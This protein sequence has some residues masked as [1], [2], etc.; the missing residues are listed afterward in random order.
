MSGEVVRPDQR[1]RET[2]FYIPAKDAPERP[3]YTLKHNDTFAV[4][5]SHGDIGVASGESDGMFNQDTRFL[6]RLEL[7]V[8]NKP[9]LLLGSGVRSDNEM[10][11]A[12]LTNPDFI[13]DHGNI[14]LSKDS[15]H[16]VRTLFVWND[17]LFTR[18]G[19]HNFAD[20]DVELQMDL[21]FGN[22]FADIFEA[23]GM[24][25]AKRG[26]EATAVLD[27]NDV[28]LQYTSL[29]GVPYTTTVHFDPAPNLLSEHRATYR[30]RLPPKGR[31]SVFIAIAVGKIHNKRGSDFFLN[32]RSSA[33]ARV[34]TCQSDI[35]VHTSSD[36]FNQIV[37][38]SLADLRL[39]MTHTPE[40]NYP[41]AG[42]PWYSTTFGRDG[43][44][45]A[46]QLL[47]C[48]PSV[49]SGVLRKL[50]ALQATA[51]DPANDAEPGKIIHEMRKGEMARLR[52]VP[53]GRYYGS[54]D[55]TPLFVLLAGEYA[56][57]TGDFDLIS[58]LWPNIE[59]AL[60]WID[61]H[62]LK[63]P[64]GFLRHARNS[65][66]G[67]V[68]QG[69]K[70][71]YDSIFHA[72]GSLA[73]G[74]IALVEVQ[75][76]VVAAKRSIAPVARQLGFKEKADRLL[77]DADELASRI[78]QFFWSE[79]LNI[80]GI[81]LDGKGRLCRV[82][83]SNAGHVLYSGAASHDRAR[84]VMQTML[85]PT[86]LSGWGL[87]TVADGE[88]RYNP[89]SYHNGSIWPH[90]NAL[91][92]LGFARYGF[93][94]AAATVLEALSGAAS[95][96]ELNRLPELFC[97]FRRSKGQAP[98]NYPVACS[99]QA[100]ASATPLALLQACLGFAFDVRQHR[101]SVLNP[102]LPSFID[103]AVVRNLQIGA[104]LVDVGFYRDN[105]GAVQSEVLRNEAN[106]EVV[107][108]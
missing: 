78:E 26:V 61:S 66:D 1:T 4:I 74:T 9:T 92:A 105:R 21:L 38:R 99:P 31:S 77:R 33:R 90:D 94:G 100:W 44:I 107:T 81:A 64:D 82:K 14:L 10:V 19:I 68:N 40:G 39:L 47:W 95:R 88:S 11:R 12:D 98:T 42:V 96:M 27:P 49:A 85:S 50:A 62:S 58:K 101:I 108:S 41:Y 59:A 3:R 24:R 48:M 52:E 5:D 22:D 56:E 53:F 71:S 15:I 16:I 86:F 72:D 83:T 103:K 79:E 30:L 45:T 7:L 25:R 43:L 69:W 13:D 106:V 20:R 97:G 104:H 75:A 54:V 18:L 29:D 57:R 70:D 51:F 76:Y 60:E 87:R 102:V 93:K 65:E 46:L 89:M 2:P 36:I 80:Y 6:S 23:R 73:E 84:R 63:D 55:A 32:L 91:A 8:N 34:R 37:A 67:L 17:T 28:E 35:D